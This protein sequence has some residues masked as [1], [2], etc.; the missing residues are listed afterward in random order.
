MAC[1]VTVSQMSPLSCREDTT[2]K[3]RKQDKKLTGR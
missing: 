1:V 2:E 3:D